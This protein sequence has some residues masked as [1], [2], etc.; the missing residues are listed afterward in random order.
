M[1][2]TFLIVIFIGGAAIAFFVRFL[3]ALYKESRS[4]GM[5]RV[6]MVNVNPRRKEN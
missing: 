5:D 2:A 6:K 3:I 1:A 4:P